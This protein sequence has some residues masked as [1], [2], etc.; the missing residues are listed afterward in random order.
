MDLPRT[1]SSNLNGKK[2]IITGGNSG[3]GLACSVA[4]AESGA[5]VFILAR[6]MEKSQ[7]AVDAITKCGWQAQAVALDVTDTDAMRKVLRDLPL[8]TVLVNNA[9]INRPDDFVK[10]TEKDFDDIMN[11]NVRAAFF[12]A[13]EF[14]RKLVDAEQP[15]SII[16]MSSQ[17]A[18]VGGIQRSVYCASKHAM[19]GF[20][21]AMAWELGPQQIRVN[22]ICPTFF[23][24][25]LT[26]PMFEDKEFIK[27]V[28]S[29]IA[30]KKIGYP[31]DI[32][33]A[34]QFL[35]GDGSGMV[36]GSALKIDGGWTAI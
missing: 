22:T 21:K 27:N 33:A 20:T 10:V 32:M 25:P 26:E 8:C 1:P 13:Q 30:L 11:T 34:V 6:N 12:T 17:M 36:T 28:V 14:S 24:S 35:A 5:E 31:Q 7:A 18:Y 9:G 23:A 15:G 4:L 2:A 3:L 19:E 29:R 16:N